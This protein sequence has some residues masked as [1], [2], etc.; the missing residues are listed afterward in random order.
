[1]EENLYEHKSK[2]RKEIGDEMSK[3]ENLEREILDYNEWIM[4]LEQEMKDASAKEREATKKLHK[5]KALCYERLQKLR[6]ETQARRDTE[7]EL[8]N[9]AKALSHTEEELQIV[10][11]LYELSNNTKLHMKKEWDTSLRN[12]RGGSRQWPT[13]VV[14]LI[15]ELLVHGTAPTAIPNNIQTLYTTLY[16]KVPEEL[17]SVNYVREC[18]VVVEVMC[19]TMA[20][21]KLA[22]SPEWGQLFTD[23]TSRRQISFTAL[24]VGVLSDAGQINPIVISSCIFSEEE[25]SQSIVDAILDKVSTCN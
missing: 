10:N 20:A 8:V 15:C 4:E 2:R 17:P 19:E 24:I 13:W 12:V 25:T 18:R 1:L 9:V 6:K 11:A 14:L 5:S 21:I 7:D 22:E 23:G 16:G 3:R